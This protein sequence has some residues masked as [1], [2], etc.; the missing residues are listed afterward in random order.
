MINF[1]CGICRRSVRSN[2]KAI[3]CSICKFWIH[4]K[5]NGLTRK[6]YEFLKTQ[7]TLKNLGIALNASTIFFLLALMSPLLST[8]TLFPR[9]KKSDSSHS[10]TLLKSVSFLN[11]WVELTA[12]IMSQMNSLPSNLALINSLSSI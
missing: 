2:H 6:D 1:P 8:I 5:C 10:S 3:E 11:Q 4:I 7:K 12:N 9:L